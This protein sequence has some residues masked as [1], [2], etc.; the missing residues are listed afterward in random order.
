MP[1]KERRVMSLKLEFIERAKAQDANISALCRE[2]GITRQTGHK[3]IKRFEQQ[4]YD[5][6]DEQSRR[7]KR[8]PLA[9]GEEVVLAVLEAREAHPR[10][11]AR[12]LVVLLQRRFGA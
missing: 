8:S 10:W 12:K 5:G 11:G 7:P 4:G 1:W 6:L 9:L 3:W 2:F